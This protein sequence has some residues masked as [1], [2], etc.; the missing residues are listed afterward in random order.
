[1][2]DWVF[3]T[4]DMTFHIYDVETQKKIGQQLNSMF[5]KLPNQQPKK[6]C[7]EYLG[8]III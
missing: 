5:T 6:N 2:P 7:G 1:M 3:N 8:S 4:D